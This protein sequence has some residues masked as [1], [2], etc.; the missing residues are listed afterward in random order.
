MHISQ[1]FCF[2]VL[3]Q[4]LYDVGMFQIKLLPLKKNNRLKQIPLSLYIPNEI[5]NQIVTTVL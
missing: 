2:K 4:S 1:Q 3:H 5:N